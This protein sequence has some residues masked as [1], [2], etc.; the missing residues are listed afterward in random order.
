MDQFNYPLENLEWSPQD[1]QKLYDSG[2]DIQFIDIRENG[3]K[4]EVSFQGL[5]LPL[6]I[7]QESRQKIS[8]DKPVILFCRS[9][10]RSLHAVK[11]LREFY[12]F[13][14]VY[15]LKGGILELFKSRTLGGIINILVD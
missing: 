8:H 2:V 3:E 9:G 13:N 1:I 10:T 7:L 14:N 4:P 12:Q 11:M 5:V 6:S 15:S